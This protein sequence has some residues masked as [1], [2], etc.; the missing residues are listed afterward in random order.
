MGYPEP[1]R[2]FSDEIL[3]R[4]RCAEID[5]LGSRCQLVVGHDG[6]HL[7]ERD[8]QRLAWPVGAE[9][10]LRPPWAISLPAT[11]TRRASRSQG[12]GIEVVINR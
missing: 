4:Y 2:D 3:D 11:R 7:L 1:H 5:G 6:Q 12:D 9:P 10:H 8:G